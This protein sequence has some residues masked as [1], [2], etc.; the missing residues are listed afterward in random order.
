MEDNNFDE[1]RI[2]ET[3]MEDPIV[4]VEP[5]KPQPKQK[6]KEENV[7]FSYI[8]EMIVCFVI[9]LVVSHFI[10]RPVVVKGSSM[11]PT[12][13]D[14]SYGLSNTI[15][16]TFGGVKR[17]DI[18]ILYVPEHKEYLVKRVIALPNETVE[19]RNQQLYING[20]PIAEDF[21]NEEIKQ[22]YG[23]SFMNDVSKITLKEGEYYCLGDNRPN[24]RDS[25][26]YG[27]FQ[28]SQIVSK[29]IMVVYPFQDF[30]LKNW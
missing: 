13:H 12:L 5:P 6:K 26:Y 9:A 23:Q 18:V 4:D 15:G 24:S 11:Y 28:K 7:L 14:G 17:F 10:T 25:R 19:Y 27:P 1:T 30:G 20:E 3:L 21:L 22:Q 29:G 16:Y 2:M 8:K